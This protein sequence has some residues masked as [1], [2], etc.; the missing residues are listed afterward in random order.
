MPRGSAEFSETEHLRYGHCRSD[1]KKME[2]GIYGE[3]HRAECP[4][5]KI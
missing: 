1:K 2:D 5:Q 3:R 4:L